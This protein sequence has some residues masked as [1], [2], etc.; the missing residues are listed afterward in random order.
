MDT[1]Q[2]KSNFIIYLSILVVFG[3]ITVILSSI[4]LDESKQYIRYDLILIY[5]L[6]IY[7]TIVLVHTSRTTKY[8]RDF[9]PE[10][11]GKYR[12]SI[13]SYKWKGYFSTLT[14]EDTNLLVIKKDYDS[15]KI[16][17]IVHI[18][19]MFILLSI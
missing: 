8:L 19:L 6:L 11:W 15:M 13:A 7:P 1:K 4:G 2:Y 16:F 14:T 10:I 18:I 12:T 3:L 17:H 9:Y 5:F